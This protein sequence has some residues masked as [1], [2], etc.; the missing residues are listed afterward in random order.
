MRKKKFFSK[1]I[2][3]PTVKK[4]K[5]TCRFEIVMSMFFCER[6]NETSIKQKV[7]PH[8]EKHDIF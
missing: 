4:T 8:P 3:L 1:F 6:N 5:K 2:S 7:T